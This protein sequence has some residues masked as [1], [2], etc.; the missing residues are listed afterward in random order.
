ML[1]KNRK[2]IGSPAEGLAYLSKG[3][4]CKRKQLR[5]AT[6]ALQALKPTALNQ[7]RGETRNKVS[8]PFFTKD[9]SMFSH[10]P[11]TCV[12]EFIYIIYMR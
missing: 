12:N 2:G 10:I 3:V 7:E 11:R 4:D 9:N 1:D 8:N 6:I 5:V